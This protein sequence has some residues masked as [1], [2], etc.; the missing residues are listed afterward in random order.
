MVDMTDHLTDAMMVEIT[1]NI[2]YH[3]HDGCTDGSNDGCFDG[4]IDTSNSMSNTYKPP[5]TVITNL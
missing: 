3:N 4:C 5:Q 1:A 2:Y